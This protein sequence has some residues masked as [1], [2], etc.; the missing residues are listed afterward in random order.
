PV[1]ARRRKAERR[2]PAED[3]G[4]VQRGGGAAAEDGAAEPGPGH[5]RAAELDPDGARA[6]RGRGE[7]RAQAG[8][9]PRS[10]PAQLELGLTP[11]RGPYP[12]R[13]AQAADPAGALVPLGQP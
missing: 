8:R 1:T 5:A 13:A 7:R 6:E 11:A 10:G 12:S 9:G 3:G 4:P 2:G